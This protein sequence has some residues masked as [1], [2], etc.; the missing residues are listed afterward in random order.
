[1]YIETVPNRNSPPAILLRESY[2]D[3][4]KVKKRTLLNL[5]D[6]PTEIVEGFRTV[7]KGGKFA[8]KGDE[9]IVVRRSLPHGHVA[10]VLGALRQTGVDRLLGPVGDRARDLVVAMIVLRLIA[11]ASKLATARMLDPETAATSLGEVLALG[12]VDENELYAAL[13]WLFE[14]QGSIEN[15]LARKHLHDGTLVLYDVSSSYVEGRCCELAKHGYSR[16]RKKGKLQIVY[17]LLCAKDGCPVA[18]EVF[19]GNTADPSTLKDQIDKIKKRF[20]LQRVVLV[21]DRGMITQARIDE[22]LRPAGLDWITALRAPD[23]KAL[24]AGGALQMSLFDERDLASIASPDFPDER[25]VVCR[26]PDLAKLRAHKREELLEATED[27]LSKIAK[28]VARA[29]KPWRGAAKIG[30]RVG[31]VVNHHKMAKHFELVIEDAGFSFSRKQDE[32]AAEALL[33]GVYVVRSPV[34]ATDLDDAA[35]V[36]AYKSLGQVERAFR[37]IKTIDLHLRPIHHWNA[38]R[39]RA[40][41]FLCMLAL[42]VEHHMRKKLAPILFDET[43][44]E[45][46]SA[47]RASIVAKAQRS[48]P[49]K[50]KEATGRTPDGLPVHSLRTLLA[51][52]ATFGRLEATTALNENYVFTLY[53]RPTPTQQRAFQLL[54]V[55]AERS[56]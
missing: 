54:G 10:V 21:G 28:A 40:H 12:D 16:D 30:V 11:P 52:L 44:R 27:D 55:N 8:P 23:I 1:M 2:R 25:L 31:K 24:A 36:G 17:G 26:N 20:G 19:E 49:A 5:T 7:L 9:P 43:D 34:P 35:L 46:A 41:V 51:D 3:G 38:T 39:V 32:I 53:T 14:R 6:F 47:A 50:D 48:Q 42:H 33:D 37:C 22:E 18:V 4:G 29:K 56:Q 13:D 45:A 15:A